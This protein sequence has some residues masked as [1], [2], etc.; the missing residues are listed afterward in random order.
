MPLT[1]TNTQNQIRGIIVPKAAERRDCHAVIAQIDFDDLGRG[2]GTLHTSGVAR[3]DMQGRTFGG[4]A[5][6]QVQIGGA[7]AAAV[8]VANSVLGTKDQTNQR[9]VSNAV[10]SALNQ[11]LDTCKVWEVAGELP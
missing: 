9:G 8:M 5:N 4:D 3:I 1:K 10:I 11:S 2:S 6:I 7:T